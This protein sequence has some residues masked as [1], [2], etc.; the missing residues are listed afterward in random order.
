M[1]DELTVIY[2]GSCPICSREIAAYRARAERAGAGVRFI[3]L[4][5]DDVSRFGLTRDAAARRFYAVA[6]D[7]RVLDGVPAFA[8]LWERLPGLRRLAR[9]ARTPGVR[10]IAAVVYDRIAAPLLYRMHVARE[11]KS[12]AGA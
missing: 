5:T 9:L 2:N 8:L 11:A 10:R 12:R 3:D 7:G 4:A 1:K 6:P